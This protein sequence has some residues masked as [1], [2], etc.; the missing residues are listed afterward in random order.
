MF[1]AFL[2]TFLDTID[3]FLV[4]AAV[5]AFARKT[6]QTS[7][8]TAIGG[9]VAASVPASAAG[10]WWMSRADDIAVWERRFAMLAIVAVAAVASFM[11]RSRRLLGATHGT[12]VP[13]H[14]S[15]W[16]AVFLFTVIVLSREGM[17]TLVLLIILVLQV[18]VIEL[19]IGVIASLALAAGLSWAWARLGH[20]V[21]RPW[22]AVATAIILLLATSQ[23]VSDAIRSTA[24]PRS[25]LPV[26]GNR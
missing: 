24:A 5:A 20:R 10:A 26:D 7:L 4:V 13:A 23:I 14:R 21:W 15:T 19:R 8:L 3:A 9:G 6:G 25:P 22:F 1:A 11:W 2:L 17:H 16:V 18:P 12:R